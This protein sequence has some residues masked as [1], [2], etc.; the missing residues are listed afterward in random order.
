MLAP[1]GQI[2]SLVT[3]DLHGIGSVDEHSSVVRFCE[4]RDGHTDAD[5]PILLDLSEIG[6][7]ELPNLVALDI[8]RCCGATADFLNNIISN[9]PGRY[10]DTRAVSPSMIYI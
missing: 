8:H 6:S 10:A 3:L 7:L 5:S 2:K 4:G 9:A 1:L